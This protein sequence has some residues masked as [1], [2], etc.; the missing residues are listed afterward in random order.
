MPCKG[1]R[2]SRK[3]YRGYRSLGAGAALLALALAVASAALPARAGKAVRQGA[4]KEAPNL[5]LITLDTT[6]ADHLGAWGWP[7]AHTPNLD[8]LAAR[9]SRF[10]RCDTA[11]PI[12]LVSHA[13]LLSGLF[14]PRHG[15]RDNGTFVLPERIST[16]AERLAARGYDTAAVVSAVVL[17]R[18]QGLAQGFRIYD[19]DLGAGY[20]QGTMVSERPAEQTTAAAS[21][22]L[23]GL[24][25]PFF[26]W[27]HYFDPHEE[28]RPPTRFADA[29]KG[30][31][32]LYDG[33][34]AYMDEQIGV[35]L[36]KLPPAT[37]VVAV[38]DHGEMLGEHGEL[39]HGLLLY[40][41]VR[42]VPLILAGPGIPAGAVRRALVRTVDVTP[43]LLAL[44]GL[45][46]P[47]DLDGRS[48][49]PLP[50]DR[51]SR[52]S[53][54]ESFLPFF[55]YK[56][57]PLR[58]FAID[59]RLYLQAP[60]PA[61]YAED[62][63]A[64]EA[65]DLAP[66][67][68]AAAARLRGELAAFL[69]ARGEGLDPAVRAD[70]VLTAEQRAQLA[71]L[72]YSGGGAGGQVTGSLPDPR[73]MTEVAQALHRA[74]AQVQQGQCAQAL[75]E[76]QRIVQKDPHNFPAL[77]LAGT[78]LKQ[79][80]RADSALALFTRA[81]KENP[82]SAVPVANAAGALLAL[83][84][85]AD[86]EREYRHALALD[87]TQPETA[88]NL[89]RLLRGRGDRKAALA[90]LDGALAGGA[91]SAEIFAERGLARAEGGDLA[92]ALADF[93]EA[94]HRSPADPA[95][96]EN[97]AHASFELGRYRES[98]ILY[99]DLLR[100]AENRLDDWKILGTIYLDRLNDHPNALRCFRRALLLETDAAERAKL[101]G[102]IK[103]LDG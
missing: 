83:G 97:A 12:T 40:Q 30:P 5:V 86:A 92:G 89:A 65:R 72:G 91:H 90:V 3:R 35:L 70:N 49:L 80:G 101:E 27:V 56:W 16:V 29:A 48:L 63:G 98:A 68:P 7:Y 20:A 26:L 15:V 60:H 62:A 13:T 1:A 2:R 31:H 41:A 75:P 10:V 42:R 93:R 66:A 25:R 44:A 18:R 33:E 94:S 58:A 95:P 19:D 8:A 24:K 17:A 53:Y 39:T 74:A 64:A 22:A 73:A 78:C 67:E 45:P 34:I 47:A 11:A 21:A 28:Y 43:T 32:R 87:P 52:P 76:L 57:Y 23:A 59:R 71:S 38:G 82:L 100:L 37:D 51:A 81:G 84:R 14:P 103:E 61:L 55:A 77:D 6:R 69:R 99:E 102:L 85:K 9:G 50:D 88:A 4:A 54:T 96:L 79:G 36:R 46:P